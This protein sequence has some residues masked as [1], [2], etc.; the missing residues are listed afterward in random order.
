MP[1]ALNESI[2]TSSVPVLGGTE[3][4]NM[5]LSIVV[6]IAAI[7]LVGWI[8]SKSRALSPSAGDIINIVATRALGPKDRLLV[9]EVA[10]QQL[11]L[12]MT[13]A[14]VRTLHVFDKRVVI[15]EAAAPSLNFAA[16]LRAS[17]QE[18]RR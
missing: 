13:T 18:M 4:L 17:L 11:L 7:L 12:G 6:V 8:Y 9:V 3:L 10:D 16:R 14:G 2:A 5:G 15:P 1:S